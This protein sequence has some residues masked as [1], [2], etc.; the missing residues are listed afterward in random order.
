MRMTRIWAL[1]SLLVLPVA[2]DAGTTLRHVPITPEIGPFP[3]DLLTVVDPQ[4]KTGR[5][6]NMPAAPACPPA[7]IE[8]VA[9]APGDS[10][11]VAKQLLNQL[12]GFSVKPQFNIC[13]SGP[14]DPD[15]LK[16]GMAVAPAHGSAPAIG[17][18]HVLY[19][20]TTNCVLA[21]PDHVLDQSTRYLL[22]VSN[23][24]RG[25]DG[26]PVVAD[27]AFKSCAMGGGSAY[28]SAL[29]NALTSG[30]REARAV[31]VVGASVFTTMS[32]TDWLQKARKFLYTSHVKPTVLPAGPKNIFKVADLQ[33]FEWLPQTNIAIPDPFDPIAIPTE[34]LEG[35]EKV[36]FGLY[37]SPNFLQVSGPLPGT[38]AVTPTNRPIQAPVPVDD[39]SG[40]IPISYHVFLPHA[41]PGAKIPVVIYVHGSGDSQFGAPTVIASTLAKAGFATLA[42]EIVG[43]GFG[44]ESFVRLMDSTGTYK[45]A[46]PGRSVPF[47]TDGS[48]VPGDGCQAPGP[49]AVRDCLRQSAVDIMALVQNIKANGLGVKLDGSRV[50]LVGQSLGSFIGSLVHA[51]EP[52]VKA[53]V[54]NVGGDSVV[55]TARQAY[56]DDTD[57]GYLLAYNP[58]LLDVAGDALGSP[59]FDFYYPYRGPVMQ[60]DTPGV[61]DIQRAFEV[62]DWVN[63]P[64][65]PLAYAP[66]FKQKPLPGVP[67][68]PTLFQFGWGDLEV[69]NPVESNLVRAYAGPAQSPFAAL[70]VQ[71]FR[72]DLAL[73]VDPH[74][75]YVFMPGATYSILPHRYLANPSIVEP[76]NVDELLLM[77]EVQR[78]VVRFFKSGTTA[79]L[80]PF[81]LNPSLATLPTTRHFTWP[82][83]VAPAQ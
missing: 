49:I 74:L 26:I 77:L 39:P 36:A 40:Y 81:F 60:T 80:P 34:V 79:V 23:R 62:A 82:I 54:I 61:S 66:H 75:A 6:V 70:P 3:S 11:E 63:V 43:H 15:T 29:A 10:C 19:D 18:N 12:D 72:F 1:C 4:Q 25:A 31:T 59:D 73:A 38:I 53:A 65:A 21:K 52:G 51:V 27:D 2:A 56:G 7:P 78:Q 8:R 58:A 83:Q 22:F 17:I 30:P 37:L 68:K 44:S 28:C 16:G 35:V 32:A 47:R 46:A 5:H 48:I 41:G 14:I 9:Q 20:S 69:A 33:V 42:M 13:F 24:V 45:V 50:Y 71:Y 76:S 67:V 55:D 64:G 57:I